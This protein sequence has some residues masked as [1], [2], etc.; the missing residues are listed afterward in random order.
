MQLV[1][2]LGDEIEQK[3]L[4]SPEVGNLTFFGE[5]VYDFVLRIWV[6]WRWHFTISVQVVDKKLNSQKGWE[7]M[8]LQILFLGPSNLL[9]PTASF[10]Q[11]SQ[12]LGEN[13]SPNLV[14]GSIK[15]LETTTSF[16]QLQ[17]LFVSPIVK[18]LVFSEVKR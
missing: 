7:R 15:P 9:Q 18:T 10:A 1:K 4:S 13:G 3:V 11:T 5:F 6:M 2:E 17:K 16:A 14:P 12:K 8:A